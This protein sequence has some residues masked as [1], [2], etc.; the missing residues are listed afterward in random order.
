MK[1]AII[2]AAGRTGMQVVLQA[3][4]R[5]YE[6]TAVVRTPSNV[7]VRHDNLSVVQ[8]DVTDLETLVCAFGGCD[9]V[10]S[11]LGTGTSRSATTVYSAGVA[12]ELKAMHSLGIST[13]A[14][15]SAAP[16]GPRQEQPF[17]E[18]RVAMP[19]LERFFGPI[20]E[21]MRRMETLLEGADVDWTCLRP[22][23]LVD[24]PMTGAYRIDAKPLPK[25][26]SL[27]FGDLAAALLDSLAE[28]ERHRHAAY[29]A[30]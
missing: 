3:I 23:R 7:T 4:E 20:Y 17:L 30:N 18:R 5:G 19:L 2:G 16:V 8:G 11:A 25:A 13:L 29:V 28:P 12:N 14:V 26:R 22:P 15:I 10:I 21:D 6:A 27:T 9:A 1:V 24:K